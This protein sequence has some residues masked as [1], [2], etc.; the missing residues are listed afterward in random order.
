MSPPKIGFFLGAL[1]GIVFILANFW[2]MRQRFRQVSQAARDEGQDI[3]VYLHLPRQWDLAKNKGAI[4]S[5][6]DSD[7]L[8][9]KK[10]ELLRQHASF[11]RR[12]VL[13]GAAIAMGAFA[14]AFLAMLIFGN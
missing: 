13:G 6:A 3:E 8:R 9:E 4:F 1:P 14:G 11:V 7:E 5:P 2:T 12:H 10:K